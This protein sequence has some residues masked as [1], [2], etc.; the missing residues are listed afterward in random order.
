[1]CLLLIPVI[2]LFF[3][4]CSDGSENS[5]TSDART[6]V[7]FSL[8]VAC[9]NMESYVLAGSSEGSK[10]NTRFSSYYSGSVEKS[11][12]IKQEGR[13]INL[14]DFPV[15][16]T[17][18]SGTEGRIEVDGTNKVLA[19]KSYEAYVIGGNWRWDDSGVFYKTTLSR[20]GNFGTWLK[21]S[22]TNR[23]SKATANIA[24][25]EEGLII[26]NK[27]GSPIKFKHKGFEAEKK[28]YYSYAEV[29]IDNGK[30][31]NTKEGEAESEIRDIPVFT[32]SNA[33]F[34]YS[35][36]VPNGNKIHDAQLIAEIDGKEVR[37]VNRISS[38][39]ILQF[40]HCYAMFAVWD[41][42]KLTLGDG[43]SEPAVIDVTNTEI[44]GVNVVSL[45]ND[46]TI[47]IETTE[48]KAPKVGDILC[49][50]P[51]EQ[52]PFGYMLRVTD[53]TKASSNAH[54]TRAFD[55]LQ[56]WIFL[57]KTVAASLNEV[58]GNFHY[59]QHI[60]LKDIQIDKVTDNEGNS[61]E[62]IKEKEREWK[63]PMTIN[64]GKNLTVTPEIVIKPK[65]FVFY[66]DIKDKEF[67]KFGADVDFDIDASLQIDAKLDSKFEKS[68]SL[69]YIIL[70][71]I[72]ICAEPPVVITPLFQVYLTFKADGHIK[73]SCV[74]VRNTYSIHAGAYYDFQQEKV[75]SSAG[76]DFYTI[77]QQEN[78]RNANTIEGGLTFDGSV[79]ASLGASLSLGID[80]CN[81]VGR[82][83][84]LSKKLDFLADMATVDFS[85]SL[86]T[87]EFKTKFGIDNIK[88]EA[89][90]DFHFYDECKL[91]NY[92]ELNLQ[93]FLRVWN[94]IKQKFVGF[95]PTP[96]HIRRNHWELWDNNLYPTLFVPEYT[97][98]SATINGGN[99]IIN[100]KKY[101]PYF[102]NTLFKE[103]GYGF[104]YGKYVDSSTK[105]S[106]WKNVTVRNVIGNAD[107]PLC[108]VD[109]VIPMN[110]IEKGQTYFICPYV[111][112]LTPAG[113]YTYIHRK[114]IFIRVNNNGTLTYNELLN[115]PGIDL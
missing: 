30:V 103:K 84:F 78:K 17:N 107:D 114:G 3:Q 67:Q 59:S 41:G 85:Y 10:V 9:P 15:A 86:N 113:S 62:V 68:I 49:S 89:W 81:Y 22:S 77:S 46:G 19:D 98:L 12:L 38:D 54:S 76:N 20:G 11:V 110:E 100:A 58:L 42:E 112:V 91:D 105:I 50:G 82:V 34:I 40:N 8:D 16:I 28:W 108:Y 35:I 104:R 1:M 60:N 39:V 101:K 23:P 72:P 13:I 88:P 7:K 57:V 32:G 37:S 53:V 33:R 111:Y 96:V 97:N 75:M 48:E 5:E 102:E 79:S 43:N 95:D 115:I 31:V 83:D 2:A 69:F 63:V 44:S 80:G 26:L 61:L 65:D 52:A 47:T 99:V 66:V 4:A 55:D 29:S 92:E 73:L 36:Y 51:T 94:P 70:K 64:L 71:P 25:T 56:T 18:S 109:G 14:G 93:F 27:S 24:G 106:S 87:I 74:P 21:F 90:N 45:E 6:S